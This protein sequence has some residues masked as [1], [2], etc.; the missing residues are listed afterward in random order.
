MGPSRQGFGS[1]RNLGGRDIEPAI[2]TIALATVSMSSV[3]R[4]TRT[5]L[6]QTRLGRILLI[7]VRF[8]TALGYYTPQLKRA[9][10]WAL[11]S[12]EVANFTFEI[13]QAN[14]NYLAHTV[15]VITG[16]T[17]EAVMGYFRELQEDDS[18]RRHV[19]AGISKSSMRYSADVRCDFGRRLGWYAFVRILKPHV[20]VETGVDKG[21]G[22]VTLCAALLRNATDGFPGR[23]FGTDKNPEAGFLL[24]DPYDKVGEI[25]YG[26]SL[27]SLHSIPKIDIFINDSDHSAEYE[28]REY[29]LIAPKLGMAGLILGD[30]CHCNDVLAR[31][32]LEQGRQF[33]FFQEQP[34]D[35]WYPGAGIGI[36][37]MA[38]GGLAERLLA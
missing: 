10:A 36:S 37:F 11:S 12:R 26:D 17:H 34:K 21:L 22:S 3:K 27:E 5:F 38:R 8:R 18:L 24:T 6:L 33:I 32:S 4:R 2:Q 29:E 30:N 31:F 9:V 16:V 25:L 20:V 35:H 13:T 28:R 1:P 19:I 15:S 7:P 14:C 23:Y